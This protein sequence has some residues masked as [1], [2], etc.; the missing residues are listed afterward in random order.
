MKPLKDIDQEQQ[1]IPVC[2]WL[3]C[4]VNPAPAKQ[5]LLRTLICLDNESLQ[6]TD[7]TFR[8][9]NMLGL[10]FRWSQEI[11]TEI[12]EKECSELHQCAYLLEC[13]NALTCT[14]S[15]NHAQSALMLYYKSCQPSPAYQCHSVWACLCLQAR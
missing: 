13:A 14:A 2:R 4:A 1:M 5:K 15:P 7:L 12:V 6:A 3:L 9:E 10:L 11:V 8:P